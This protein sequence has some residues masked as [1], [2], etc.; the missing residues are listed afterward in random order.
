MKP[1]LSSSTNL[2]LRRKKL[3]AFCWKRNKNRTPIVEVCFS[4]GVRWFFFGLL[5]KTNSL[6][7]Y[8]R[9]FS[10][11]DTCVRWC[12]ANWLFGRNFN[13][14]PKKNL[15]AAIV[16]VR[17]TKQW[18]L[19]HGW[20]AGPSPM[21]GGG[22]GGVRWGNET[23]SISHFVWNGRTDRPTDERVKASVRFGRSMWRFERKLVAN[24]RRKKKQ[25]VRFLD[26]V[27]GISCS[28]FER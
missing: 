28:S 12:A 22:G 7:S 17:W 8:P 15:F 16:V 18:M 26:G 9:Y 3:F 19:P 20:L 14:K 13:P 11:F 27:G 10:L 1:R 5:K 2:R 25:L 24:A 23:F 21:V 6:N 4:T